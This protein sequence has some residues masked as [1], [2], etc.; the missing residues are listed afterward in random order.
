MFT[1]GLNRAV[2]LLGREGRAVRAGATVLKNLGAHPELRRRGAGFLRAL[3]SLCEARQGQ[4]D[5]PKEPRARSRSPWRKRCQLIAAKSAQGLPKRPKPQSG[6]AEKGARRQKRSRQE[7]AA[8]ILPPRNAGQ[9]ERPVAKPKRP[10]KN[11]PQGRFLRSKRFSNSSDSSG[12]TGKREIARAFNVKGGDRI[13]PE[14]LLRE[15]GRRRVDRR[16]EPE[17]CAARGSAAGAVL[18]IVGDDRMATLSPSRST[19]AEDAGPAA[20]RADDVKA[21]R[22]RRRR[23]HRR[24][25]SGA[26]RLALAG[27]RLRLYRRGRSRSCRA[28][29]EPAR[30]LP[31]ACRRGGIIDPIDKKQ[32]KEWRVA[33]GATEAPRTANWSASRTKAGR[34]LRRAA[35]A[36]CRSARQSGGSNA[37]P[38]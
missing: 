10:Q 20:T 7:S 2:S 14:E 19:W 21:S 26:H 6:E 12:K 36:D 5:A 38:V 18:E 16:Q 32:L 1:V 11:R 3:R 37:P 8:V 4:C 29:H 23:G 31:H 9:L 35:R 17:A 13:T 22:T 27:R 34:T 15:H 24:P 25:C 30:H 28:T 33:R